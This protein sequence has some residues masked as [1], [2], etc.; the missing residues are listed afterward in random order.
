M[1]EDGSVFGVRGR[2]RKCLVL[3]LI[4]LFGLLALAEIS[5]AGAQPWLGSEFRNRHEGSR[6]YPEDQ[7]RLEARSTTCGFPWTYSRGLHRCVCVRAGYSVQQGACAPDGASASCGDRERW[8]PRTAA[9]VCAKG[10]DRANGVCVEGDDETATSGPALPGTDSVAPADPRA[11]ATLRAQ[12]CLQ[13]LGLYKGP[14]DGVVNNDTWTAFWYFKRDQGLKSYGDFV[15]TP[16]QEKFAS[17]CKSPEQTAAAT[18]AATPSSSDAGLTE[19]AVI[20]EKETARVFTPV[21]IDCVP[22]NLLAQLRQH[23]VGG[24]ALKACTDSCLPAPKGLAQAD[25]DA[26]AA[27]H[28]L[29][30]CNSCV[31]IEGQLPLA[32]IQRIEK[33][34]NIQLCATPPNQLP[35]MS[36]LE[37]D[38]A[39]YTRIRELYRGLPPAGT[40]ENAIALIVGD[41]NYAAYPHDETAA[42][43]AGAIYAF[44]T[45]H[46][47]YAPDNIIDVRDAKKLELERLFGAGEGADSTLSRLARA[48]Q[49]ANVVIYYAGLGATDEAQSE[50]YLLPVD[51]ERFREERSGYKLST[52]Y[53]NLQKLGAKS[54][55]VLLE[56]DF[57]REQGPYLLPPNAPETMRSVLPSS[58]LPGVSILAAADRGQ[59]RLIDPI[60]GV[61]L[62]TRYLI[63]GLSGEADRIPLG[64]GDGAVD[65]SEIF[66]YSTVM[67]ELAARKS[68]GLMQN[69]VY[70]GTVAPIV[71]GR[72]RD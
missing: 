65:S 46:L 42:N 43:E 38:D 54:V 25:L 44:L 57:G 72:T 35:L 18:P 56:A 68:F 62:F 4:L 26:L 66:A 52:L 24:S 48:H 49:G 64:N 8:S 60:Y 21:E 16:V 27:R 50:T 29:H 63:E 14:V 12:S 47:G 15:A 71:A 40:P 67:V 69:P 33:A 53:A 70:S 9:C 19:H 32:D 28:G 7:P 55:L 22:A 34:G 1:P 11:E 31:S 6:I 39:A 17:L 10:L 51:A 37:R 41:R 23:R 59:R 58:P 20:P 3:L 5:P 36:G 45:E 30:W 2:D 61:G 13:Q